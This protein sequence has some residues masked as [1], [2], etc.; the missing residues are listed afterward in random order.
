[1][2]KKYIRFID[3]AYNDRFFIEDGGNIIFT[4]CDGEEKRLQC[5]Y[6]DETHTQVGNNTYHICQFAEI[7]ERNGHTVRPEKHIDDLS[8][9]SKRYLA[10]DNINKAGKPV[11]YRLLDRTE[12]RGFGFCPEPE[13]FKKFCIFSIDPMITEQRIFGNRLEDIL[14]KPVAAG[15]DH[16]KIRA[17][18]S[19][20]ESLYGRFLTEYEGFIAGLKKKPGDEIIESAHEIAIKKDVLQ[21]LETGAFEEEVEEVLSG[22]KIT[23]DKIYLNWIQ[24]DMRY[25]Q[26]LRDV[27]EGIAV[28]K[29]LG[30][31]DQMEMEI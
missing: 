13:A 26:D 10:R 22:D 16:E 28:E 17:I 18:V 7:M 8:F 5:K 12:E 23:L 2:D 24:K 15:F 9:Y 27:I 29:R 6:L 11:C 3:S 31:D 14:S 1:M 21:L 25:I 20:N 4:S 19:A 30:R